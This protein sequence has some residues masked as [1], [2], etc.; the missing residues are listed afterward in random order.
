MVVVVALVVEEPRGAVFDLF[1]WAGDEEVTSDLIPGTVC[2][3]SPAE[4]VEPGFAFVSIAFSGFGA[5]EEDDVK[6]LGEVVGVF[7]G[8]GEAIDEEVA[9]VGGGVFEEGVK[10]V[11]LGGAQY[12]R[13]N[14][15]RFDFIV[16]LA[17]GTAIATKAQQGH[18]DQLR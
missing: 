4:V 2:F 8:F 16:L 5:V 3:E 9:F 11:G 15:N 14:W 1:F 17:S 7:L 12:W 13:S 18:G 6:D 10:L